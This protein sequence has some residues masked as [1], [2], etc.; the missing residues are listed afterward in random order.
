MKNLTKHI[1]VLVL[2]TGLSCSI[3]SSL[4]AQAI[5]YKAVITSPAQQ[6]IALAATKSKVWANGDT[7]HFVY[8]GLANNLSLWSL[9]KQPMTRLNRHT[10]VASIWFPQLHKARVNGHFI[11][12]KPSFKFVKNVSWTGKNALPMPPKKAQLKG[13]QKKHLVYSK[14]LQANR[15]VEVYLPPGFSK[16]A[17][18]YPVVF[19][20]DGIGKSATYIE[21][22]ITSKQ[23]PPVV[24]IGVPPGNKEVSKKQGTDARSIEYLEAYNTT[25]KIPLK[26][27]LHFD[28]F[29]HFYTKELMTW[30][31]KNW[32]ISANP[33]KR[34]MTG[35]SN[36]A[37]FAAYIARAYPHLFGHVIPL[38]FGWSPTKDK[39]ENMNPST[40]PK[41][42]FAAGQLEPGYMK[43]TKAL[44]KLLKNKGYKIQET[45]PLAGHN[46][47]MWQRVLVGYLQ[48]IF[49]TTRETPKQKH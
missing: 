9:V 44:A 29:V 36:G 47:H 35:N 39:W 33:V 11:Q 42:Y 18:S 38:S 17:I 12:T 30:A 19:I 26:D 22:L 46:H 21:P 2:L 37:G 1:C 6:Q 20:M 16:N 27:S 45:Y 28:K 7:L 10:L 40:K 31:D 25:F 8:K 32:R 23:I 43:E 24:L 5:K 15:E 48:D 4:T 34:L 3:A 49:G 14:A 41:M 13:T